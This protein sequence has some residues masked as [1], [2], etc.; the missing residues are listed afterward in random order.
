MEGFIAEMVFFISFRSLT[1]EVQVQMTAN[2][3]VP[4]FSIN[5]MD[6]YIQNYFVHNKSYFLKFRI[7]FI[8]NKDI[9]LKNSQVY[10]TLGRVWASDLKRVE[11][12]ISGASAH[13]IKKI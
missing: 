8:K 5:R 3:P 4:I 11:V 9:F 10:E 13:L 2:Y 7:T 6:L 12:Q 1:P